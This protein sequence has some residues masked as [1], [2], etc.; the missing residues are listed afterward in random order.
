[1]GTLGRRGAAVA[2]ELGVS[3]RRDGV[4]VPPLPLDD[5]GGVAGREALVSVRVGS[6]SSRSW[7][8]FIM[9]DIDAYPG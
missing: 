2:A 5:V 3:R 9:A 6:V 7:T 4:V 8:G 1:L